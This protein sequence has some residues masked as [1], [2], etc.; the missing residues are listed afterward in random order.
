MSEPII[1]QIEV[2]CGPKHAFEVFTR[3]VDLWWPIGHRKFDQSAL[4]FDCQNG[5][6]FIERSTDGEVFELGTILDWDPPRRF[7]YSWIRGAIAKPTEVEV[8]FKPQGTTTLV[9][10]THSEAG[11]ELGDA[12]PI[13]A[14]GFRKAWSHLLPALADVI[15]RNERDG[16]TP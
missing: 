1:S 9:V 14:E 8:E 11:S 4:E 12:W 6:R 3:K 16:E 13:R 7:R 10:V 2:R 5:G 15:A